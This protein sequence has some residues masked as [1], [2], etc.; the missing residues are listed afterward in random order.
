MDFTTLG[1]IVMSG[2][3]P[4]ELK[5]EARRFAMMGDDILALPLPN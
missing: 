1:A 3:G 5:D 4:Q 2:I